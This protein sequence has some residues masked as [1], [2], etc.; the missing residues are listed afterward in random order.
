MPVPVPPALPL[1]DSE[2]Q[3]LCLSL[4]TPMGMASL[5]CL[6]VVSDDI[7]LLRSD[8]QKACS[9]VFPGLSWYFCL[10]VLSY[11]SYLGVA[12]K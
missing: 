7:R 3:D 12:L 5:S 11:P 8:V 10:G 4:Q 1:P 2:P 9:H 6:P